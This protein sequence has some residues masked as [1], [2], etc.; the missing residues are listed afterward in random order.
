[1]CVCVRAHISPVKSQRVV[2][3]EKVGSAQQVCVTHPSPS[4]AH[5]LPFDHCPLMTV[6]SG[7]QLVLSDEF[8]DGLPLLAVLAHPGY[9][10][11]AGLALF[12]K[13]L[14]FANIR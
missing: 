13:R 10:F 12:R 8:A 6:H 7:C 9:A 14:T 2:K 5:G 1:M 3:E 4:L 11:H